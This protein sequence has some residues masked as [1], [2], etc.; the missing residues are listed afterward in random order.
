MRQNMN[1]LF[2]YFV[3]CAHF[4]VMIYMIISQRIFKILQEKILNKRIYLTKVYISTTEKLSAIA[5]ELSISLNYL[6]TG[7][8]AD[9]LHSQTFPPTES[10]VLLADYEKLSSISML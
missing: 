4:Q 1:L 2:L 5:Q 3:Y 9:C 8:D 10:Q 7:E 6:H